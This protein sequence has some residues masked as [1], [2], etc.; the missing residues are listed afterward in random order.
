MPT[1]PASLPRPRADGFKSAPL[2]S[3]VAFQSDKVNVEKRRRVN[4]ARFYAVSFSM[5]CTAAQVAA[6]DDFYFGD[7]GGGSLPFTWTHP[8]S[9]LTGQAQFTEEPVAVPKPRT[10]RYLVTVA[11]KFRV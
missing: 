9:S 2:K 7:C 4:T 10:G 11:L 6:M 5:T 3:Y 1:W 8:V